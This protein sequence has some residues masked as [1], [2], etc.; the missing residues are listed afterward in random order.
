MEPFSKDIEKAL[1]F[2]KEGIY[3]NVLVKTPNAQ[4][5]L[6]CFAKGASIDEHTSAK[7]AVLY[8]V[9]GKGTFLLRSKEVA[10]EKGKLL[11]FPAHTPHAV[12]AEEE[13]AFLLYL[14]KTGEQ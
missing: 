6:M 2:P 4:V 14:G 8:V 12:S 9:K 7:D 3:S 13:L 5:T 1:Q 10:L 11:F